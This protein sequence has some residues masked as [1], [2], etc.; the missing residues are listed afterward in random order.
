MEAFV[1]KSFGLSL[2]FWFSFRFIPRNKFDE[3][4]GVDIIKSINNKNCQIA[5]QD[6]S[7]CLTTLPAPS[8]IK[9]K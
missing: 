2:F 9:I 1:H 7:T 5:F 6:E 8:V 3:S 4:K